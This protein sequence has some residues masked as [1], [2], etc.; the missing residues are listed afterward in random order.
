MSEQV[1]DVTQPG[2]WR[3]ITVPGEHEFTV[4]WG[5]TTGSPTYGVPPNRYLTV[6]LPHQCDEWTIANAERGLERTKAEIIAEVEQFIAEAQQALAVL[7][8]EVPDEWSGG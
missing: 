1:P 6:A 7:R 2:G 5:T 3:E 8:R 4:R